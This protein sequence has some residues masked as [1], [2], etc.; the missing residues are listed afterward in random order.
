MR[1][2]ITIRALVE[3]PSSKHPNQLETAARQTVAAIPKN[4]RVFGFKTL[5]TEFVFGNPSK[6]ENIRL[7]PRKR[8]YGFFGAPVCA[9]RVVPKDRVTEDWKKV[10]CKQCLKKKPQLSPQKE[11]FA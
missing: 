11:L 5:G 2:L 4:L 1:Q 10:T 7:T 8:H 6:E 9:D 3:F